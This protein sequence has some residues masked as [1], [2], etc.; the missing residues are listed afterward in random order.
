MEKKKKKKMGLSK[1][2]TT[3]PYSYKYLV[4][5]IRRPISHIPQPEPKPTQMA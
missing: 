3:I 4:N 5:L 1:P 2:R